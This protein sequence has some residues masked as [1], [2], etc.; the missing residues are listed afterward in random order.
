MQ[1]NTDSICEYLEWDSHFFSQ[2]IARARIHRLTEE[3]A[4]ELRSWCE[5]NRIDCIYFLADSSHAQTVR[6]AEASNFNFVDI[7]LT[8]YHSAKSKSNLTCKYAHSRV[9]EAVEA[10]IPTLR[11]IARSSHR[12]SRF[13]FDGNFPRSLCDALYEVWI[14]KS[15]R[16]WATK[17]FVAEDEGSA[18][19]YITCHLRT[20]QVGQIGLVAVGEKAHGKGLGME[21]VVRA[22][23]WFAEQKVENVSVV[24][25]GRNAVAQR[26]YQ[27]TGFVTESL[28]LWYHRWFARAE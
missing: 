19:G 8:L 5:L 26:L 18:V 25:Q 13:Y 1:T 11:S 14:E 6:L 24:T 23:R 9:R 10:D 17:V 16:G 21:L 2:R 27:R 20:A 28:E 3:T 4:V 12:D 22:L 7:R 15:F